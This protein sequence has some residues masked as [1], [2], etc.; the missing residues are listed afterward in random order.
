VLSLEEALEKL[1]ASINAV[2]GQERLSL[3]NGVGRLVA[4]DVAAP[5]PLPLFDNS[6]MDGWA[7]RSADVVTANSDRPVTLECIANIPA[8]CIF[9][10]EI[11]QG[12]CARIFTGSPLPAGADG[13][14]MQEDARAKLPHV[15]IF[16][17][18]KPWENVRFKGEDVKQGAMVAQSGS[19]LNA[20]TSALLSACG[21]A[22]ITVKRRI[23]VAILATGNE[24]RNSGATLR[25]GE[26]YEGNRILLATVIRQLGGEPIE[27]PIVGDDLAETIQAIRSASA[28]GDAIITC[29]GVSVGE[30]DF[31]KEAVTQLGGIFIFWRVAIKPGKP[32]AHA[33][34]LGKPLFGL[35]GNPVSALVTF[36]LLVRPALL[37]MAG[38]AEL[39]PP[40]SF[41]KL[42]EPISNQGDRRHFVRVFLDSEGN[43]RPTG[44]QASHRLKSLASANALLDV[45]PDTTWEIGRTV[46]VILLP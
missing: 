22:E 18:V 42:S 10:G 29:G 4:Q 20:Q 16:D 5:N 25:A 35:P 21:V 28:E 12:Q 38:A 33:K 45:P 17:A 1:L 37:R 19:R 15:E 27:F 43:V 9:S 44:P 32:F 46:K 24:L 31:V 2:T 23:R 41:G 39:E 40:V 11:K 3:A 14:V 26:I 36:W 6:A 13:V 34:V 30:Y 7:V 8:G